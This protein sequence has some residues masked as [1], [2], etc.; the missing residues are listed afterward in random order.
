[1]T[2][3]E[4]FVSMVEHIDNTIAIPAIQ[5]ICI[6]PPTNDM[7]KS[8]KFG[9]M[10]LEDSTI[11]LTYVGLNNALHHLHQN[12]QWR[13]LVG[14]STVDAARLYS[15]ETN[16]ERVLGMAAINAISQYVLQKSKFPRS[17][18]SKTIHGLDLGK[19][20]KI[21]MV[22]FFPPLVE[23]IRALNIPLTVL[24]LDPQWLDRQENFEVTLD[25]ENLGD[26]N[27][28]IC[29]ATTLINHSLDSVLGYIQGAASINIIGPTAGCLPDP[30]FD[31]GVTSIGGSC[32]TD[33]NRFMQMWSNQEPW[34]ESAERYSIHQNTY[35]GVNRLLEKCV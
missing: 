22:G 27:K 9:V 11:G 16:W 4:Q 10:I 12:S 34:R 33:S 35:P 15:S 19:Q 28:V 7:Q 3:A 1:M 17:S 25:P 30:L 23:Q 13:S 2:L 21:G 18:V 14:G 29:T 20:D 6:S 5:E 32:I 31:R 24:E 26:C 8:S